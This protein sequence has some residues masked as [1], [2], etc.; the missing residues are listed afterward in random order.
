MTER[1]QTKVYKLYCGSHAVGSTWPWGGAGVAPGNVA[2]AKG[3]ASPREGT[4]RT[5]VR[6]RDRS[7]EH[8]LAG[9]LTAV[10]WERLAWGGCPSATGSSYAHTWFPGSR[11]GSRQDSSGAGLCSTRP[12][13]VVGT[14]SA[15]AGG[16]TRPWVQTEV[17][18]T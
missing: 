11:S 8:V 10:A 12:A 18:L 9:S 14:E 4:R 3:E 7:P 13:R 2:S 5:G 16:R 15:G 6:G 17:T 1:T